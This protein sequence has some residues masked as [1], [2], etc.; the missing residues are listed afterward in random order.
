M[1]SRSNV[2]ILKKGKETPR[3]LRILFALDCYILGC[4]STDRNQ[5]EHRGS[6]RASSTARE[7]G[8]WGHIQAASDILR[9]HPGSLGHLGHTQTTSDIWGHLRQ[10]RTRI[11]HPGS[12]EQSELGAGGKLSQVQHKSQLNY[13]VMH[14]GT[15]P[16]PFTCMSWQDHLPDITGEICYQRHF[17]W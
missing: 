8:K 9:A 16:L 11:T 1:Y 5:I 10:P 13:F 14:I 6:C 4:F 3:Q 12:P 15:P 2:P 17:T 7:V